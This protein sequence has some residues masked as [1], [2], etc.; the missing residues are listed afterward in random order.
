MAR[1]NFL[2]CTKPL[3]AQNLKGT[4]PTR[5]LYQVGFGTRE[6]LLESGHL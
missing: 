4:P 6:L 3:L 5:S 2:K 1:V